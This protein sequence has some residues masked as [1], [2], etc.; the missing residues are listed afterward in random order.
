MTMRIL[1]IY[2]TF[3]PEEY[4][5]CELAVKNISQVTAQLGCK[6]T[7]LTTSKTKNIKYDNHAYMDV[8]RIPH[9]FAYASCPV[10]FSLFKHFREQARQA[11]II[12]YH[13]PWPFADLLHFMTQ[14]DKPTILS[15]QCDIIKQVQ[16]KRIYNPLMHWFLKKMNV[17][18]ANTQNYLDTSTDLMPY[19]DK[20]RVIHLGINGN[21]YPEPEEALLEKWQAQ[22]GNNFLL[23]IGML[24]H[25]KGLDV[26]LD[27]IKNSNIPVVI[28]GDGPLRDDLL[29]HAA[30]NQLQNVQF[31]GR[32]SDTDKCALLRLSQAV[33]LPSNSRA[34]AYGLSL[35]EGLMY[36]K[37][38]ISTELGT[39]TSVVN[40]DG[41]TGMVIP[42]NNAGALRQA[43][44][45]LFDDPAR[46]IAM[47]KQGRKDYEQLYT[48]DVMGKHY[49]DLYEE[50]IRT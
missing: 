49:F 15:Y 45:T 13:F 46:A 19:L 44:Q 25:Y 16:L 26:L 9:T 47:G 32:I 1:H 29:A 22:V 31:V 20:S 37:P 36:A 38:L 28:A 35:I 34:E 11:D 27:A 10:S 39:G 41:E 42:A 17:I 6:N 48:A 2:K 23:F 40:R 8:I 43:I 18:V 12:H 4:G 50:L 24:R 30:Q 7:L 3:F 14:V 21:D 5:G 33:V